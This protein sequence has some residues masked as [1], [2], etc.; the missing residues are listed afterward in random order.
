MSWGNG[1]SDHLT[2]ASRLHF[3]ELWPLGHDQNPGSLTETTTMIVLNA[4]ENVE[5]VELDLEDQRKVKGGRVAV[6][7]GTGEKS[8]SGVSDY[9]YEAAWHLFYY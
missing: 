8:Y 2:L 3:Y 6:G 1:E 5:A 7:T 9:I 4:L